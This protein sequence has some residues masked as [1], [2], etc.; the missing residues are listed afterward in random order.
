M[1]KGQIWQLDFF[2]ALVISTIAIV[3]F[4]N[5]ITDQTASTKISDL[6]ISSSSM[7]EILMTQG[8]PIDWTNESVRAIGLLESTGRISESK[9]STL[10]QMTPNQYRL[11]FTEKHLYQIRI[12]SDGNPLTIEGKEYIGF[13]ASNATSAISSS[14]YGLYNQEIVQVEVIVW[15]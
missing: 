3:F 1:K 7:S 2:I 9:V 10:Y 11:Y 14:R 13:N 15:N 6:A 8:L 5:F 4:V 12:L